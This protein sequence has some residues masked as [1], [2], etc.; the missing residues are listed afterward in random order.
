MPAKDYISL[1]YERVAAET[2]LAYC[3]VFPDIVPVWIP[4]SLIDPDFLPL[5][6]SGGEVSVELWKAEQE[7]LLD[8]AS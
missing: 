1:D 4:K 6:E 7:D 8:F 3:L 5:E 2:D